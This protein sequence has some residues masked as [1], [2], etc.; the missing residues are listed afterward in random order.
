MIDCCKRRQTWWGRI[1]QRGQGGSSCH[2]PEG[3]KGARTQERAEK[4]KHKAKP[5]LACPVGQVLPTSH[6]VKSSQPPYQAGTLIISIFKKRKLRHRE[7]QKP[8]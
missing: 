7:S 3:D 1:L 8:S 6:L 2:G 4:G 5:D